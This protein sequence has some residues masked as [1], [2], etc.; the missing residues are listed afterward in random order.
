MAKLMR[1]MVL[2]LALVAVFGGVLGGGGSAEAANGYE[3]WT[4]PYNDGCYYYWDGFAY[5]MGGCPRADGGFDFYVDNGFGQWTF[6]FSSGYLADG[7]VWTYYGGQY[8]YST[9]STTAGHYPDSMIIGGGGYSGMT[10]NVVVD[11]ILI[12]SNNAI[13][14]NILAPNCV[15]VVG[16]VCYTW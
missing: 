9:P 15:E 10:G 4:G 3:Q 6:S 16:G 12:D 14:D 8:Y 7:T 2:V 1:A 5:T 13:I 11:Q